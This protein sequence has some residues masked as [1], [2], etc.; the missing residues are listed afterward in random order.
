[1]HYSLLINAFLLLKLNKKELIM[2]Q[3]NKKTYYHVWD[4]EQDLMANV[5]DDVTLPDGGRIRAN[6]GKLAIK[7][8]D[9]LYFDH[10]RSMGVSTR[11]GKGYE[12][13]FPHGKV[14]LHGSGVSLILEQ[15]QSKFVKPVD[16][17]K[18][19]FDAKVEA[20]KTRITPEIENL[21][22]VFIFEETQRRSEAKRVRAENEQRNKDKVKNAV[23]QMSA[24]FNKPKQ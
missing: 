15:D 19:E 22:D 13:E 7:K 1:M 6:I 24:A 16:S 17:S 3:E 14:V 11:S 20:Q 4:S 12:S 23:N 9:A 21:K 8:G 18:E 2:E 5:T 10:G